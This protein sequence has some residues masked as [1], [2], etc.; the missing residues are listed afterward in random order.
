MT[1]R[2]NQKP[3][4]AAEALRK[5]KRRKI[6]GSVLCVALAWLLWTAYRAAV[7][8][9]NGKEIGRQNAAFS[10][11]YFIGDSSRP[12]Q[13]LLVLGDSTAAGWGAGKVENTFAYK[14]AQ[15]L[16]QKG[17]RVHV[18][19]V[20]VGGA[21]LQDVIRSQIAS[22]EKLKPQVVVVS[23]GAN[24]ATQ[25]TDEIEYSNH[26]RTLLDTLQK[27]TK[28][29]LFANT[30]DMFQAP[31]LPLPLAL[32]ANNRARRQN[33]L[34]QKIAHGSS[35]RIVDI[36]GRGKLIYE[37]DPNLYAA[38]LFHPSGKGYDVWAQLFIEQL[39]GK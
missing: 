20:A 32:L 14:I 38:D 2:K 17:F 3:V 26:L 37:R 39:P 30:P 31:A 8:L 34:L 23:I 12:T 28:V 6:G 15:A 22:F 27:N 9:R 11:D 4:S 16:P 10:R 7:L 29:V 24:D 36:Y 25:G 35:V 1:F 18:V 5:T 21:R 19:N 13:T 33:E